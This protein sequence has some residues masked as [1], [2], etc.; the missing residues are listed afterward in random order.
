MWMLRR[1]LMPSRRQNIHE[2]A[3]GQQLPVENCRLQSALLVPSLPVSGAPR[4]GPL[5]APRSLLPSRPPWPTSP[6]SCSPPPPHYPA[7]QV[8]CPHARDGREALDCLIP[9]LCI[10]CSYWVSRVDAACSLTSGHWV[11]TCVLT[12][13]LAKV[14]WAFIWNVDRHVWSGTCHLYL[15]KHRHPCVVLV[16]TC[17]M[18]MIRHRFTQWFL[19]RHLLCVNSMVIDQAQLF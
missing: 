6:F 13:C 10:W 11:V 3:K 18:P 1:K 16:E 4:P 9:C 8:V 14:T 17:H 19:T 15:V 2:R 12:Q 5:S 7:E